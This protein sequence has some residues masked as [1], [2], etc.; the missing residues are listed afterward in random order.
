MGTW[1]APEATSGIVSRNAAS[2]FGSMSGWFR[3]KPLTTMRLTIR[4]NGLIATG[5][6]PRHATVS[7][8]CPDLVECAVFIHDH[9]VTADGLQLGDELR[10]THE[11]DRLDAPR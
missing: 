8:C 9:E 3:K 2:I 6:P 1:I 11:I 7:D 4:S 10:S 5:P